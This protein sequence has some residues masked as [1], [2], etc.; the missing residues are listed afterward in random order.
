MTNTQSKMVEEKE[1]L[2]CGSHTSHSW[3][4]IMLFEGDEDAEIAD[5]DA[6]D[7]WRQH[8]ICEECVNLEG[9]RQRCIL[10]VMNS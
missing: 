7:G 10:R 8:H 1:C 2:F 9:G 3:M 6:D 4:N 5:D